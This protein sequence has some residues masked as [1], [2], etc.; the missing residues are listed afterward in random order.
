MLELQTKT[1]GREGDKRNCANIIWGQ[2][3]ARNTVCIQLY[4]R[5]LIHSGVP[6]GTALGV[7]VKRGERPLEGV[8]VAG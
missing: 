2:C 8:G 4:F 1:R 6:L 3:P 7:M 5:R